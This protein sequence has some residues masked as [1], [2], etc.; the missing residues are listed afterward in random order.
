MT[1]SRSRTAT[2]HGR[3]CSADAR[4]RVERARAVVDAR[5]RARKPVYGVNTGF[6][7]FAEVRIDAD[8]LDALQVNL[9]RSHAAGVGAPLSDGGACAR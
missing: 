3:R 4:T 9:L 2:P 5:P 6:G 1:S 8:A 7:S